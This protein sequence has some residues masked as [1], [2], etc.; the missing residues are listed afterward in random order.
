MEYIIYGIL[1]ILWIGFT[2]LCFSGGGDRNY[3]SSDDGT[4]GGNTGGF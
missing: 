2:Y 3:N 1:G 4:G